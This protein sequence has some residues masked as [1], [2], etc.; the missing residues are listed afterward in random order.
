VITIT[1]IITAG[2][3]FL[4]SQLGIVKNPLIVFLIIAVIIG[5]SSF[6]FKDRLACP[7]AK[8]CPFSF[9]P[10]NKAE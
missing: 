1:L 8:K 10:L 3:I 5:S 7:F 6:I 9:C 2:V 4:L